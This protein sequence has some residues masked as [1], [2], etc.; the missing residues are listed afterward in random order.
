MQEQKKVLQHLLEDE[1]ETANPK[2]ALNGNI[3]D[4]SDRNENS[5]DKDNPLS[6]E[7]DY[8]PNDDL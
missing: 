8:D 1:I 6:T 4:D 2:N 7:E 5:P 3:K